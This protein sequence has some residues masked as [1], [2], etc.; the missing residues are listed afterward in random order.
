MEA[1]ILEW[2]GSA[3]GVLVRLAASLFLALNVGAV[4]A[5]GIKR[6][7]S[8]VNKWTSPWLAAN[9]TLVG[10]GLGAPLLIG[11]AKFCVRMMASTGH[12]LVQ[13]SQ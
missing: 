2:L 7:R 9:M 12:F 10:V 5:V 6:D 3:N 1:S 13:L 8:F 4:L 11:M